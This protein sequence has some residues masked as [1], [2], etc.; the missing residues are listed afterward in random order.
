MVCFKLSLPGGYAHENKQFPSSSRLLSA[1]QRLKPSDACQPENI[2][3]Y[4][5]LP[6]K[7]CQYLVLSLLRY[8]V[9]NCDI[10]QCTYFQVFFLSRNQRHDAKKCECPPLE[11]RKPRGLTMHLP[12]AKPFSDKK[13]WVTPQVT[14]HM[15]QGCEGAKRY[16]IRIAR[17]DV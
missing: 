8:V 16:G 2:W 10:V 17:I 15:R 5:H 3:L 7:H 13:M 9:R 11:V 1:N 6:L 4:T 14:Q 12:H